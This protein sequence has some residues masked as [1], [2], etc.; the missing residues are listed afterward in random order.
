MS[1]KPRLLGASLSHSASAPSIAERIASVYE[2]SGHLTLRDIVCH[3]HEGVV[4]LRGR[5]PSF[6]CK[7]LA[8]SLIASLP[9]VLEVSNLLEVRGGL[10]QDAGSSP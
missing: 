1:V 6:Y 7:Q 4:I 3:E 8:Q 2:Q 5:V 10:A 9:G